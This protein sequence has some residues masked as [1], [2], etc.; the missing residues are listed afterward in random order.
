MPGG[1]SQQ[2]LDEIRGRIDIVE[3]VGQ[4]VKLKGRTGRASA[5]STPRR[6]PHSP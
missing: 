4:F 5:P 2:H 3:I 1:F 6:R